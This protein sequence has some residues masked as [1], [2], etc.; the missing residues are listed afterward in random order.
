MRRRQLNKWMVRKVRM[1]LILRTHSDDSEMLEIVK[2]T[3]FLRTFSKIIFLSML[4]NTQYF[5][6]GWMSLINTCEP[7][8]SIRYY[9]QCYDRFVSLHN[10]PI[11][12]IRKIYNSNQFTEVHL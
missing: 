5:I 6:L 7:Y 8:V 4:L 1:M 11:K 3:D 2:L 9:K 12:L 10:K